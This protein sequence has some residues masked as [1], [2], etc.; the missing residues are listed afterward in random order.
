VAD[1]FE[2]AY[3]YGR[4]CG[5][6]STMNLGAKGAGI[7]RDSS[8][9][10]IWKLYFDQEIPDKPE[11]WILTTLERKAIRRSVDKF[12]AL[13]RPVLVSDT[14]ANALSAKYEIEAVKS[15]LF[16]LAASEA[17]PDAILFSSPMTEKALAAWPRMKDMFEGTAYDWIDGA[18]LVDLGVAENRL[19]REYY[20]NLWRAAATL[21]KRMVGNIPALILKDIQYQNLIWAL[22]VRRYYGYTAERTMPLLVTIDGEDTTSLAKSTFGLDIDNL[23]TFG[24]WPEKKLLSS[25]TTARLDVPAMELRAQRELFAIQRRSLHMYPFGYTPLYCYFK[26]L[27]AE[28]SLVLGILEGIRLKAPVEEKIDLAWA[29]LGESV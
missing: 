2:I 1:S 12:L 19:D 21:P 3:L 15:M 16:R 13:A 20:R 25:Q 8:L 18:A 4:I 28:A 26:M 27:E 14:F 11:A 10:D 7:A 23:G 5:A 24:S 22:R 6:F 29:L 17:K 9:S